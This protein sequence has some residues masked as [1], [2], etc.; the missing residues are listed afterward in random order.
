MVENSQQLSNSYDKDGY[1]VIR[2]YFD[3]AQIASLRKVVLKFHKLWKAD[4]KEFYQEEAFNS[5]LI[6]GSEYLAIDDRTVLFNFISS[7]KIMQVVDAVIPNNP[8]F[9]NT[10][11]FFNPVNPQQKDFWH[12][13]CQYDYDID[14][15][16]RVILETQ[17]LHLRIPLFDEPG[18]EII[19]GTHKRW[20]NEEEYNVRQE[21]NGK[22]SNDNISGGKQIALA[23]GDLLVFSAD[24]I[25]RGLYGLDRLALDILIFD[26]AAD[27]VDYV[28]D[29]CLP[30]PS[31]LN[32]I[33]DPRLFMN[34]LQL[35]S[36]ACA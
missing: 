27:Y 31:I 9:M 18:M 26:S 13:D 11:L 36:M 28:D 21:V 12:R 16:M 32:N 8:A 35:K 29:D 6:T 15:Q 5:S 24:M 17:V 3:D 19:P 30:T 1:F 25:H 33:V 10:Q 14:D 23:A 22:L 34:T 7:K 2:N 20:D 4:N